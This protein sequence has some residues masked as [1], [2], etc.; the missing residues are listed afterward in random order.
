MK[1][2]V[3]LPFRLLSSIL[4]LVFPL[5][6]PSAASGVVDGDAKKAAESWLSD[7]SLPVPEA[8]ESVE[9]LTRQQAE[10]ATQALW[11]L[12]Q[13]E[14]V[15][16]NES[17]A[18][19]RPTVVGRAGEVELE[20]GELKTG[21]K[22]MPFHFLQRGESDKQKP[23]FIALHGGGGA[24][25][26]G[27]HAWPVNTREWQTQTRFAT[28]IYPDDAVYFVP[29]MADD[30]DGRWY[31]GYC[32]DAYDRVVR[33]AIR[34]HNVDPNRVYL[35]GISEGAYTAYRLGAFM[36][37]RWAGAGSM[38]GGE[39]LNNAPPANMRNLA[40]RADIGERDTMFDRLG[41]NQRYEEALAKLKHDDPDGFEYMIEVHEGRG[42]GIEYRSCPQWVF[43]FTR[44]P[45]PERV[46]WVNIDVHGRRRMQ[47]YWLAL[48]AAPEGQLELDARIDRDTNTVSV[49]VARREGEN[50]IPDNTTSFRVYLN[51]ALV[52]LDRPVRV[53]RNGDEVA[54]G[55][56]ERRLATMV[57]TLA[58]RGDPNYCFPAVIEVAGQ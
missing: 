42:H 19:P 47:S 4:F 41:L 18:L 54:N 1:I 48:D 31:Y 55:P 14:S 33:E 50:L 49:D 34:Y 16:S 56:V 7:T 13:S 46:R 21:E 38:A 30:R 6:S 24:P 53:L 25:V 57:Q 45:W 22:T 29:R 58:E 35:I 32:Q 39:P 37:D 52:D 26:G 8:L 51:D 5:I 40:F 44:N 36:A 15:G 9:P 11:K 10:T 28:T 20:P 3:A 2:P 23:M 12:Y 17:K 43:N 27:P